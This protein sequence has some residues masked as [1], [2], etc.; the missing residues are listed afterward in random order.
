[1]RKI[2]LKQPQDVRRLLSRVINMSLADEIETSRA[3]SLSTLCNVLLRAMVESALEERVE[4]LERLIEN[5]SEVKNERIK[6]AS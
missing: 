2:N 5:K 4:K 6:K 3:N 1:M